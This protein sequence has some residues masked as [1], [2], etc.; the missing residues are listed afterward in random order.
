MLS[1]I[2]F[3]RGNGRALRL[4]MALALAGCS[5]RDAPEPRA[6]A[7]PP[8]PAIEAPA[9]TRVAP[10]A[11]AAPPAVARTEEDPHRLQARYFSAATA[12]AERSEIVR[13]LGALATPEAVAA[14]GAVFRAEKRAEAKLEMIEK[15]G[16]LDPERHR[17]GRAAILALAV[18]PSQPRLVRLNA[19]EL[20]EHGDEAHW[21]PVLRGFA[22]DSDAQI[23]QA[24]ADAA[25]RIAE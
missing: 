23:R 9:A 18:A 15:L 16:D 14:L 17:A 6:I 7:P 13:T 2:L 1:E 25:A 8:P 21:L 5:E 19:L 3:R 11:E 24:A 10:R 12:P 22:T 4:L 20:L